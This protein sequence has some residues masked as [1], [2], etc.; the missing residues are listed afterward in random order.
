[1]VATN[2][3][4]LTL[5]GKGAVIIYGWGAVQIGGHKFQCKQI[6]GGF[7][8]QPLEGGGKFQCAAFEGGAKT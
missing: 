5:R 8:C 7:Q 2:F 6:E 4:E 1:M 3:Q